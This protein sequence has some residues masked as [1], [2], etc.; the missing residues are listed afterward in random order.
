MLKNI[1]SKS[2]CASTI[3]LHSLQIYKQVYSISYQSHVFTISTYKIMTYTPLIILLKRA[4]GIYPG[5]FLIYFTTMFTCLLAPPC[6]PLSTSISFTILS[7]VNTASS[8]SS[9]VPFGRTVN[10]SLTCHLPVP[11]FYFVLDKGGLII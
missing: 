7:N 2:L 11:Q 5:P 3:Q 8:T 10:L 4:S 1:P 6:L 9:F